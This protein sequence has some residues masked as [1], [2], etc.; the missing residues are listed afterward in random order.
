MKSPFPPFAWKSLRRGL[1]SEERRGV[2]IGVRSMLRFQRTLRDWR[3]PRL[4]PDATP[5]VSLY[6]GGRLCGCFGSDE[7]TPTERLSR[8]FFR[9]LDDARFGGVRSGERDRVVAQVSYVRRSILVNPDTAAEQIELG[10]HGVAVV[11]EGRAP[12]LLLPHVARDER[13]D[14]GELLR[15]LSRKAG[16]GEGGL[17]EQAVYLLETEDIVVRTDATEPR[18]PGLGAARAWLSSLVGSDGRVTFAIDPRARTTTA[19]GV[20]HHARASVVA[21][22]LA[23]P[24]ASP[25]QRAAAD[26]ARRRLA[27]DA[28]AA[29]AGGVVAGWPQDAAQVAGTLALMARGGVPL[30]SELLAFVSGN[31]VTRSPWHCAQVVAALGRDAP[32]ALWRACVDDLAAHPWAPW[33]VLAAHARGDRVVRERAA[34]ALVAGLR[35]DPPH[36]GAGTLTPIPEVALTALAVEALRRHPAPWSRAAVA[37]ARAFIARTQLVGDRIY[38]ALD[39]SLAAGAFPVSPVV[40]WLRGDVTGH[41]VLALQ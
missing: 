34:R 3:A 10:V 17:A 12:V 41:A 40:D 25:A 35:S 37:R 38:G 16:L 18:Q 4:A 15:R 9:A 20:M 19:V 24:G 21:Q 32:E 29:L 2:I 13:V 7:G 11:P 39:V 31:D 36:R 27:T 1:T 8:A 28:R 14:A 26:R 6:V 5:F 22:A 33:T 23:Q 30:S